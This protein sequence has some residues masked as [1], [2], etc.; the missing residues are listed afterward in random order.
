M[1]D[2]VTTFFGYVFR[3]FARLARRALIRD[4]RDRMR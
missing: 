4:I 2:L 1:L 3:G